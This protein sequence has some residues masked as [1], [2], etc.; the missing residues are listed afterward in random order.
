ML[1]VLTGA[2]VAV[3]SAQGQGI[4]SGREVRPGAAA[5]ARPHSLPA[6]ILDVPQ[7]Q[8]DR[9]EVYLNDSMAAEEELHRARLLSENGRWAEAATLLQKIA[10]DAGGHLIRAGPGHYRDLRVFTQEWI[11]S[12]PGEGIGAY[13]A[14]F[15]RAAEEALTDATADRGS[16]EHLLRVFERFFCTE[17]AGRLAD[18]IAQRAIEA[19][20]LALA[21]RV[22]A[23]V[24]AHHPD[25]GALGKRYAAMRD[26]VA[27]LRGA[28]APEDGGA[29]P[30][31][32]VRWMGQDLPL[33]EVTERI[34]RAAPIP[35]SLAGEDSWP[36]FGGNASRVRVARTTI[37]DLG[38]LW[39]HAPRASARGDSGGGGL[40]DAGEDATRLGACAVADEERVY[41]PSGSSI[42]ALNRRD[43]VVVWR[44]DPAV[45]EAP[46][47]DSLEES[48]TRWNA[49]TVDGDRIYAALQRREPGFSGFDTTREA[50]ELVCV[51]S[52]T[53]QVLWRYTAESDAAA[54]TET[55]FDA[56]PVA[57]DGRVF[58]VMR[59][60]RSFGFEDAYLAGF[61]A[62]DGRALFRTHLG[63]AST[64]VF[65]GRPSTLA[66]PAVHEDTVYV[67]TNLG[68]VAAVS[69]QTGTVRWLRLHGRDRLDALRESGRNLRETS[70][71]KVSPTLATRDRVVCYPVDATDLMVLDRSDGSTRLRVARAD[72]GETEAL[73]GMDGDAAYLAGREVLC[74]DLADG[75]IRWRSALGDQ[76][77][78][79][80]RGILT[81]EEVLVPTRTALAVFRRED[82]RRRDLNWDTQGTGGN[83]VALPDLLL[84]AGPASV[85]AYVRKSEIR[86][87]LFDAMVKSPRDA[88]PALELAEFTFRSGDFEE[89]LRFLQEALQRAGGLVGP[90]DTAVEGRF[91]RLSMLFVDILEARG[92]LGLERLEGLFLCA[93]RS[94]RTADEHVQYRLRFAPLFEQ[95]G[96]TRR[97]LSLYHQILRDR[98]L[99]ETIRTG[100]ADVTRTSG[101][102]ATERILALVAQHGSDAHAS[103]EE[104]AQRMLTDARSAGDPDTL[105]QIAEFFPVSRAAPQ[106][107]LACADV[108][109]ARHQGSNA[110]STL[111]AAY[112]R[113]RDV[114]DELD[115]MRRIADA[116]ALAGRRAHAYRWLSRAVRDYPTGR[117]LVAGQTLSIVEYRDRFQD[118]RESVEPSFASLG[119][120]LPNHDERPLDS[121]TELLSPRFDR[122]PAG[123][124][125][126]VF[127]YANGAINALSS[128]VQRVLWPEPVAVR[129][130]PE[131]LIASDDLALFATLF[132]TF[133]V[134]RKR[135]VRA[136]SSGTYPRALDDE[137]AD[138]E[139]LPVFRR[140]VLNGRRLVSIRDDGVIHC[141]D[142]HT[143]EHLW[144]SALGAPPMSGLVLT[145]DLLASG[146]LRDETGV[147]VVL[148]AAD[149]ST[150]GVIPTE[151]DRPVESLFASLDG[152]LLL[153]TSQ[154]ISA[155]DS[156]TLRR[157]WRVVVR[158]H[159]RK[160][161][162]LI[163]LDGVYYSNDGRTV[164]RL[165]LERGQ[166][167]WTSE[168]FSRDAQSDLTLTATERSLIVTGE[169]VVAALAPESGLTLWEGTTP[170]RPRF[171]RRFLTRE[172]AGVV[173][174]PPPARAAPST[175]LFYDH[176]NASGVVPRDGGVI[177]LPDWGAE[178][179]RE[180][181]PL[182]D[183]VVIHAGDVLHSWHR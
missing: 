165:S 79:F 168:T 60:R 36:V 27:A 154:S 89:G 171:V 87:R 7:G 161:S 90:A 59:R 6:S 86:T 28:Q 172:Y 104:E 85:S 42:T 152:Q 137:N 157:R 128:D 144:E 136:W 53:G 126:S 133:A 81:A 83:L 94:P 2:P 102:L 37:D 135:G 19:G 173:N 26:I 182:D 77:E 107:L 179:I 80:G 64:A 112:H 21:E 125:S 84:V 159:L 67:C 16:A 88:A 151:E 163:D 108:Q 119:L 69:A 177:S 180:L 61:R 48:M 8:G 122:D 10:D 41:V 103:F 139:G 120:P 50:V 129:Q 57:A 147:I 11:A 100:D 18:E 132:E 106:A 31:F 113:Y 17:R 68:T 95:L 55:V 150:V 91:F 92:A 145:E 25:R 33:A 124:W 93:S 138:W 44:L 73:L 29:D 74:L 183:A 75:T 65:A 40:R 115:L 47:D 82:G 140:R 116:Y 169:S 51:Q 97:A 117:V 134:D 45:K 3:P 155:Y 46:P 99:R 14:A 114:L 23:R 58:V 30:T 178:G 38:L 39:R 32:V 146:S 162:V 72:L 131:L 20:E 156:E 49:I 66:I 149:G 101:E 76:E 13:R 35:G 22:Y 96:D 148:S 1:L 170:S 176:R 167:V 78:E 98:A 160:S 9:P 24:I 142:W 127:V 109:M 12:W 141:I 43:G 52:Q 174:T 130:R 54:G 111:I 143:G 70:P 71:W 164:T 56:S 105:R 181:I 158:G 62:S 153:T 118:A 34:R 4:P 63:S 5:D 166:T 123:R 110:A 121:G 15:E 175:I